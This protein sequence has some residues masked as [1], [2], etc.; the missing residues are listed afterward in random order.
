MILIVCLDDQNGMMFNGRRQSRDSIIIDLILEEA[1]GR[2]IWM[3]WYSY[4]QFSELSCKNI[5]VDNDFLVKAKTGEYCFAENYH[6]A[7]Y[8]KKIEKII[9][10]RWNRKYPSD[11]K[12]DIDLNSDVWKQVKWQDFRGYS[13]EKITKEVYIK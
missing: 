5:K 11:F 2:I 9:I 3:N 1:A 7:N 4:K 8:G 13:H 10:F 12:L 6:V